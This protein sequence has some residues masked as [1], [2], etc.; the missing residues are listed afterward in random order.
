MDPEQRLLI[1]HKY[2]AVECDILVFCTLARVLCPQRMDIADRDRTFHDLD[3]LLR[4]ALFSLF[5]LF[6]DVLNHFVCIK[7]VFLIYR[8]ILR[9]CICFGK[10]DL[11]RHK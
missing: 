7:Q 10:E 11:Y 8:L 3:F 2:L 5:L 1:I 4:L 6:F 9:L